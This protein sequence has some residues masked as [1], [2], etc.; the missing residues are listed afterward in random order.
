MLHPL[1]PWPR[2]YHHHWQARVT[3]AADVSAASVYSTDTHHAP[4]LRFYYYPERSFRNVDP[5]LRCC[6]GAFHRH[7]HKI[8][9]KAGFCTPDGTNIE[10]LDGDL[11]LWRE[12]TGNIHSISQSTIQFQDS[13]AYNEMHIR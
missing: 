4:F 11:E 8:Q 10:P 2:I 1:W 7:H 6:N 13:E 9:L 3:T 5:D 12:V